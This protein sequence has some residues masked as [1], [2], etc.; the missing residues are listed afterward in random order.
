MEGARQLAQRDRLLLLVPLDRVGDAGVVR[1]ELLAGAHQLQPVGVE[2]RARVRLDAAE[3]VALV[4]RREHREQRLS[5]PERHLLAL[6]RNALGEEAVL[7]LVF[8]LRELRRDEAGLAGLAEP[9][10]QLAL[11][12]RDAVLRLAQGIELLAAEEVR[13]A[14]DDLR[15]LGSLLLADA[16]GT[17]L[18]G[19]L[20]EILLETLLEVRRAE[21]RSRAHVS[22][23]ASRRANS[24]SVCGLNGFVRI[25]S[26]A[27]R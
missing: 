17:P 18:L 24:T 11:V 10:Q 15:L 3:L 20:E 4:V 5:V 2:R 27:S 7:E 12:A 8:A 6:E 16:H 26:A 14:A 9:V 1:G 19:A 13:V 25:A 21:D 22:T 23:L